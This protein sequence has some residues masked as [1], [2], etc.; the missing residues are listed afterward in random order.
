MTAQPLTSD[1]I[2][3]SPARERFQ[4][5]ALDGGGVRGIFA[6]AL[7]AGLEA[8]TGRPVV[9]HFDLVVGTSTGGIIALGLGAGLTPREILD[10]YV[11][12]KARIFANPLGWRKL[13]HPFVAKYRPKAL[14]AALRRVFGETLLGESGVPLVIPSYDI[15]ENAVHLFKTPHHPRLKRD[16]RVP[17][18]AVGMATSAAPTYFPTFQLP[19]DE[20]R[21]VDGG[22]WANNPAMVGVTEAVSMFGQPLET[23]HVLSIGT[24]ASARAR[25]RRLD[26]AGLLRWVRGPNVVEVL[27]NGQSAGAFAQ[28]QHLVGP[29]HAHRLNPIAPDG[30]AELDRCDAAGLIAKGAHHSRVFCPTFEASFVGHTPAPYSPHHGPLAQAGAH[31]RQ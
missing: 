30:L 27:L 31:A 5:L 17:M 28:V 15:G 3:A 16:H 8:D 4:V 1:A 20:V 18:R 22:V 24:T 12:E 10:F 11:E 21:L 19:G 26:N 14:E 2:V 23:I 6:A 9:E 29:E 7:L 25:P 13:R